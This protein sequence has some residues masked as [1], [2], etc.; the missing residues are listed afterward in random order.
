MNKELGELQY[1]NFNTYPHYV[2]A[3]AFLVNGKLADYK[4]QNCERCWGLRTFR[5]RPWEN[6]VW[7]HGFID[8]DWNLTCEYNK[9]LVNNDEEHDEAFNK[10]EDWLFD[11]FEIYEKVNL[12]RWRF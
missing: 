2:F 3:T 1:S 11:N 12:T 8:K 10:L 7:Q 4:I 6:E 5:G 9:I